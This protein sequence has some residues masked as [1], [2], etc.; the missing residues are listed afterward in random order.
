[1]SMHLPAGWA[2]SRLGDLATA[3]QYG[4]TEKARQ[5][6][7]GPRFLRIT[8]IQDDS[9]SWEDV[10][11]CVI[12]DDDKEKY[13]LRHG[14]LVFARTGA[15]VGKSFLIRGAIPESVFASYLIRVRL[16]S[17]IDPKYISYF[18]RSNDY[19]R[20]ISESAAG[21]GQPNVNGKKLA[22][23][24][25]PV[26]PLDQQ[27]ASSRK[28][29]NNS[30]ASTKPSPISS[31]SRPTSSATK[32]PSS[33]PPSKAA[34]SK[35]KPNSPAAKAAATRPANNSCS[36][37]SKPAAASGKARAN[38]KNP[39]RPTPPTCQNCWRGGCGRLGI[40]SQ[41]G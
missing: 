12:D 6:R 17:D 9:V 36:A 11:F 2:I 40:K 13:L 28:S 4:Y 31:A 24:Q 21:I 16:R 23:I 25:I 26:A 32:P 1:M 27:N 33:K 19:W 18:F 8:D 14:D 15:T 20:Q 30:P 3:I 39:P 29:K 38:T 37:S 5:E 7:V 34:S 35:P 10:P 22:Q 41:T